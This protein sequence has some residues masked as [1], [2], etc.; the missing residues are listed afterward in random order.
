MRS[1]PITEALGAVPP[2]HVYSTAP[3]SLMKTDLSYQAFFASLNAF[4]NLLLLSPAAFLAWQQCNLGKLASSKGTERIRYQFFGWQPHPF[5][6]VKDK[7]DSERG[8]GSRPGVRAN[9]EPHGLAFGCIQA[10]P[11]V[12]QQAGFLFHLF[13]SKYFSKAPVEQAVA[14]IRWTYS[15]LKFP[16]ITPAQSSFSCFLNSH[17]NSNPPKY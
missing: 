7:N 8:C 4:L 5:W 12:R 2:S 10:A 11:A 1:Q 16:W 3:P 9:C 17:W 6:G 14:L 15:V 13:Y